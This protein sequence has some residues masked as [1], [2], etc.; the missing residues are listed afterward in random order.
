[1][2][3]VEEIKQ[4]RQ[5]H[6]MFERFKRAN[7]I[8]RQIDANV[9]KK[10]ISMIRAPHAGKKLQKVRKMGRVVVK[11]DDE[12]ESEEDMEEA[13]DSEEEEEMAVETN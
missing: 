13:Q 12:E 2:K 6:Y 8:E 11:E 9:V 10:N 1:M 4:K 5:S 7:Q 3:R